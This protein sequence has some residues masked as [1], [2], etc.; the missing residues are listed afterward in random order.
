MMMVM[1]TETAKAGETG[2]RHC[3]VEP[4]TDGWKKNRGGGGGGGRKR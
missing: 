3:D 4:E 2:G 1:E